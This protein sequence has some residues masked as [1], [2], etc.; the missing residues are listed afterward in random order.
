MCWSLSEGPFFMLRKGDLLREVSLRL[1]RRCMSVKR[2]TSVVSGWKCV[3]MILGHFF[4][5]GSY[6]YCV[7][8][9]CN[10]GGELWN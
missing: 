9:I 1:P 5:D 7:A 4:E 10:F 3:V 8:G 2:N 6:Y